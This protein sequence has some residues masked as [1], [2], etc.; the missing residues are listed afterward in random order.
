M[1]TM[2]SLAGTLCALALLCAVPAHAERSPECAECQDYQ[3]VDDELWERCQTD[4]YIGP[5]GSCMGLIAAAHYGDGASCMDD[6]ASTH[7]GEIGCYCGFA[8]FGSCLVGGASGELESAYENACTTGTS[9]EACVVEN[10]YDYNSYGIGI[11]NEFLRC[12]KDVCGEYCDQ[13]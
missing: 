2:N 13:G 11:A 3:C 8:S 5:P 10:F 9:P 12:Y 1:K 4:D 7:G 6:G